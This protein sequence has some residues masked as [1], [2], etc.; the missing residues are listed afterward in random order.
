M[1]EGDGLI[2]R[3]LHPDVAQTAL[4]E[5][6]AT[7]RS[8]LWPFARLRPMPAARP[9]EGRKPVVLVHGYMGH[10]EMLRPLAR[11]LLADGVP[12]AHR[13]GYPSLWLDMDQI[14]QRI[15]D[16]AIPAAEEHGQIDLVGHSLGAV[17][18]RAWLKRRGG[19][20]YVRRFISLGGPH[21]GTS[22]YR[23]VPGPV[24]AVFDPRG[25]WVEAL[26]EGEEP[27]PTLVIRARYDHQVFP[28]IRAAI[29]GVTERVLNGFGHNG[30]LWSPEAH[31]HAAAFLR[32][33]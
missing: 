5:A 25:R 19:A 31:G 14:V 1:S 20:R 21:A 18:C 12:A 28:P 33:G 8:G 16:V 11:A 3:V 29:P 9:R 30:L 26:A 4:R 15:A 23:F 32:E 27:V 6:A 13:V 17:A 24:R 22:L 7:L 10:R 2:G